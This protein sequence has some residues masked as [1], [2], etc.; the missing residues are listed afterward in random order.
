MD[1]KSI[2]E[3]I[4]SKTFFRDT[5]LYIFMKMGFY[6]N[7]TRGLITMDRAYLKLKK[8]YEKKIKDFKVD[9]KIKQEESNFIWI[10]WFQGLENA[11]EL[12]KKCYKSVKRWYPDND[13]VLITKENFR[14]YVDIPEYIINKW[15]NKKISNAHFSDVLRL[16]LL[17]K[18]GGLWID[19]TVFC[20]GNSWNWLKEKNLF[21]YRN[22]WLDMEYINMANWLIYSKSN[23]KI[24]IMT[25]KLLYDYWKNKN[26]AYNYFIFHMFFKMATEKYSEEWKNVT[27]Y[28]QIDNHLLSY[29]LSNDFNEK[30]YKEIKKMTNFHKLTYKIK[31]NNKKKEKTFY[32][33]IIGME[34]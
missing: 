8:R 24:L 18:Y 1:K 20:T 29:E 3:S 28:S 7:Y 19:A 34:L 11:P 21:V 26:Y 17:I 15:E 25:L 14:D 13:I 10:C 23:D 31:I 33:E 12:V 9:E 16:A 32:D 4:K 5:V 22:G 2:K 30:R 27:Y 6:S